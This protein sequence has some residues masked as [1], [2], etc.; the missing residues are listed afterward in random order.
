MFG[1]DRGVL[2]GQSVELLVPD[3]YP[4][5]RILRIGQAF[6]QPDFESHGRRRELYGRRRDGSEFPVEIGL[7]PIEMAEGLFVL[8][9]I[10]DIT[11]RRRAEETRSRL[12]AIVESSEDAILS[13]DLDGIILTWNRAAEKMYGYLGV[14]SRGSS[15][16]PCWR[17]PS[18][19]EKWRPFSS[20]FGRANASKTLRRFE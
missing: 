2:L 17:H 14:R 3:R 19:R 20:D 15:L 7:T 6:L 8:S 4:R 12:A 13:K 9:A 18:E 11:E 16:S 1:Y 5:V 10:N